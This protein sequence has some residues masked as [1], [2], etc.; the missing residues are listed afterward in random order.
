MDEI[1]LKFINNFILYNKSI[2]TELFILFNKISKKWHTK[3]NKY[4][5]IKQRVILKYESI[6]IL[7]KYNLI[8][9]YPF[10]NIKNNILLNKM[11]K[12]KLYF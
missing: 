9:V 7:Y 10:V 6:M 2:S 4:R 11:K 1:R 3:Y 12:K 5:D 8:T